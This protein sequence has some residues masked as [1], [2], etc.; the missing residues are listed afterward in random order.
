MVNEYR[1][2]TFLGPKE[3]RE[4]G[5]KGKEEEKEEEGKMGRSWGRYFVYKSR[6]MRADLREKQEA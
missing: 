5:K 6:R 1:G 4:E 2:Q 3:K